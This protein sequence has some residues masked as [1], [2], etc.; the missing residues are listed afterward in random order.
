[1]TKQRFRFYAFEN[2]SLIFIPF[3]YNNSTRI[4]SRKGRLSFYPSQGRIHSTKYEHD[5]TKTMKF[6]IQ[7]EYNWPVPG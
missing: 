4:Y 3:L 2:G 6:E 5:N 7:D 1:M